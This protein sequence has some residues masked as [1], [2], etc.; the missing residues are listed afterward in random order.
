MKLGIEE[1][2]SFGLYDKLPLNLKNIK[3][4]ESYIFLYTQDE[5]NIKL[6]I[7]EDNIVK[8]INVSLYRQIFSKAKQYKVSS[9]NVGYF[10][11][12]KFETRDGI[13]Y[14]FLRTF[15]SNDEVNNLYDYARRQDNQISA[16]IE[17]NSINEI[18]NS[19]DFKKVIGHYCP[20]RLQIISSIYDMVDNI[21]QKR[22]S[23]SLYGDLIIKSVTL[24]AYDGGVLPELNG[25][26]RYM[27]I[28][29]KANLNK[30]QK[31]NLDKAKL[32]LRSG[33]EIDNIYL[34]TGW[35]FSLYDGKWRTNISDDNAV[36]SN[37][38]FVKSDGM[39][40]LIPP[41][42]NNN[43]DDIEKVVKQPDKMYSLNYMGK[44][45]HVLNHPTIFEYYPQLKSLPLIYKMSEG[46]EQRK[47]RFY[48]ADNDRGGYIYM[49]GS[50]EWGSDISILLHELQHKIQS[51]E[52][53]AKGGN[54]F[55]ASFVSAVGGKDVRKIF[56]SINYITR[57]ITDRSNEEGVYLE[58]KS[59]FEEQVPQNETNKILL[60]E[61]RNLLETYEIFKNNV[62]ILVF[63]TIFY[64]SDNNDFSSNTLTP[65]LANIVG[66]TFYDL[67]G[68]IQ[69]SYNQTK[70][71]VNKL[72]GE[73]YGDSD[74]KRILHS[75]Y[76]NLYGE[77]ESRSVQVS[78]FVTSEF[79]NYFYLTEWE[80]SPLKNIVVIDGQEKIIDVKEIKA[81]V[82]DIK[83]KYILH[84]KKSSTSIPFIHELGHIVYDAMIKCGYSE[85]ISKNYVGH[86]E[87]RDEEE[88]FVSR[89]IGYLNNIFQDQNLMEDCFFD[90]Q[91][92]SEDSMNLIF[93]EFFK[94]DEPI[95][96]KNYI[97]LLINIVDYEYGR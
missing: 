92:S 11:G 52:G 18:S 69:E 95:V 38:Y 96:M 93:E 89:F 22:I 36:I 71:V 14:L 55:V 20:S 56:S 9:L 45:F 50:Q 97:D 8:S 1:L 63:N 91:I 59:C 61:I 87:F 23:Q 53:Y 94:D 3:L 48:Q 75:N 81:A 78:R 49:F 37:S 85:I 79:K 66:D 5:E 46:K 39:N 21:L 28:G 12:K 7:Y 90:T 60:Y 80:R 70:Q 43:I 31:E 6:N 54:Q 74:I 33:V 32:L 2:K 41:I 65:F 64:L 86:Y 35:C 82:E 67:Y 73:G 47:N 44:V 10:S 34:K 15:Y 51:I 68:E 58:L 24:I 72:K 25:R 26:L 84:F 62:S 30:E 42:G 19:S 77:L 4:E 88:Y 29:E 17:S 16:N 13:F 76:Q 57:K 27:V 83:G 40:L